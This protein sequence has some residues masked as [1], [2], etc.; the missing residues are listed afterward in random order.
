MTPPQGGPRGQ[1]PGFFNRQW[2]NPDQIRSRIAERVKEIPTAIREFGGRI[3]A[4]QGNLERQSKALTERVERL[5]QIIKGQ[6]PRPEMFHRTPPTPPMPPGGPHHGPP[7]VQPGAPK[8]PEGFS[9]E[10]RKAMEQRFEEMR[11]GAEARRPEADQLRQQAERLSNLARQLDQRQKDLDQKAKSLEQQ[12]QRLERLEK[13][14]RTR[15]EAEKRR[16]RVD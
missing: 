5:E 11:R 13:E 10:R 14:L 8:P 7:S 2:P 1:G 12:Q 15:A 3:E 16:Q 9:P 4:R 6:G